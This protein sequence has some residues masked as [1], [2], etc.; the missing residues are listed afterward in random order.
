MDKTQPS[1]DEFVKND[2]QQRSDGTLSH[3]MII[4]EEK[5]IPPAATEKNSE[6]KNIEDQG[7]DSMIEVGELQVENNIFTRIDP[8]DKGSKNLQI[9]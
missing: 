1:V 8:N 9:F 6:Q 4:V 7:K 3:R 2:L 5:Q